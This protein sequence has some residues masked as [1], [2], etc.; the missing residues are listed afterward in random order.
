MVT[1]DV[2]ML[3]SWFMMSQ[4]S[5]PWSLLC[6]WE[7]RPHLYSRLFRSKLSGGE[8]TGSIAMR[9]TNTLT[10]A[11]QASNRGTVEPI[12][13]ALCFNTATKQESEGLFPLSLWLW[14]C[15]TTLQSDQD[16]RVWTQKYSLSRTC[17]TRLEW[18]P[19]PAAMRDCAFAHR[20][21]YRPGCSVANCKMWGRNIPSEFLFELSASLRCTSFHT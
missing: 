10:W 19:P 12:L 1:N 5:N 2:C 20:Q 17:P 9:L 4:P 13:S 3:Q 15:K 18:I 7:E 11:R 14:T 16:D 6:T 21:A 8:V